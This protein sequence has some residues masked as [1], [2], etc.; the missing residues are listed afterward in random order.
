[1]RRVLL[2]VVGT[3]LVLLADFPRISASSLGPGVACLND[4]ECASGVCRER[5]ANF[6][7]FVKVSGGLDAVGSGS[8][9]GDLRY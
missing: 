9:C 2:A 1:M 6:L 5:S 4:G 8:L 7:D 3:A